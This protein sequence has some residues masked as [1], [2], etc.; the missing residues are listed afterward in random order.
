[1]KNHQ[2]LLLFLVITS[3]PSLAQDFPGYRAGNSGGVNAVFFNPANIADSRY[4]WDLNILSASGLLA[5]NNATIRFKELRDFEDDKIKTQL[6][7]SK[8]DPANGLFSGSVAGPSFMF[9]L[10]KKTSFA[11]TSRARLLINANAIDGQ[12]AS[13][14]IDQVNNGE[15]L[16]YAIRSG[17]NMRAASNGWTEFGLSAARV[18]SNKNGHFFKGGISLKYLAGSTAG[19][20]YVNNLDATLDEDKAS[21]NYILANSSGQIGVGFAGNSISNDF[22]FNDLLAFKSSGVAADIGFTYEFRPQCGS[23]KCEDGQGYKLKAGVALLDIGSIRYK[24]DNARSGSYNVDITGDEK[25]D[26]STTE[27]LDPDEFK[28]FLSDRPQYF[29]SVPEGENSVMKV[30]LPTTLQMEVDYLVHPRFYMNVAGQFSL[31]QTGDKPYNGRYYNS[32]TVT[33]RYEGRVWGVY[34]PF[35]YNGWSKMNAGLSIRAGAFF[36]GS[37]SAITALIGDSRQVDF[38]FGVRLHGPRLR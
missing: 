14:I 9:A 24:R 28:R 36:I 8:A 1:M 17:E 5:N 22:S 6:F 32:L 7:G 30:A 11:I 20:L 15:E 29:V 16:P 19:Y 2:W 31:N 3:I 12:L 25:F 13:K 27:D 35:S 26:L 23:K 37:G 10:D 4:K 38:H 18:L 21:R 34:V 33:P